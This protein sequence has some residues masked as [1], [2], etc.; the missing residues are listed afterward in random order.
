MITNF[1]NFTKNYL[2]VKKNRHQFI[3][4]QILLIFIFKY[5]MNIKH[6]MKYM[7]QCYYKLNQDCIYFIKFK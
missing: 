4:L 2:F 7:H 1:Y 3:K 5:Q 6:Q